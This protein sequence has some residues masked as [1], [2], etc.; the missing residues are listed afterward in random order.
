MKKWFASRKSSK[1]EKLPQQQQPEGSDKT[2]AATYH[3]GTNDKT[4]ISREP[5]G[6]LKED[7]GTQTELEEPDFV[8][9]P[10]PTV[11]KHMKRVPF[12]KYYSVDRVKQM[13]TQRVSIGDSE[14]D[15][16]IQRIRTQYTMS[17]HTSSL[18]N[19]KHQG[20]QEDE[21]IKLKAEMILYNKLVANFTVFMMNKSVAAADLGYR[22]VQKK[23]TH[24]R[25]I[26]IWLDQKIPEG[27]MTRKNIIPKMIDGCPVDKVIGNGHLLGAEESWLEECRNRRRLGIIENKAKENTEYR[28][29]MVRDVLIRYTCKVN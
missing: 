20:E 12:R 24:L 21:D 25:C 18:Q 29:I 13:R 7:K 23:Q 5:D 6:I 2:D 28:F 15:D 9:S 16:D 8:P 4:T 26:K 10:P 3:K 1:K 22:E 17:R 11:N 14:D 19:F 27:E